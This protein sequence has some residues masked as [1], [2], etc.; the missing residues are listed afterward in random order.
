MSNALSNYTPCSSN[1]QWPRITRIRKDTTY[2]FC[3]HTAILRSVRNGI[4][5][6]QTTDLRSDR[7]VDTRQADGGI[8]KYLVERIQAL[9]IDFCPDVEG[10]GTTW[11]FKSARH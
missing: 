8:A 4:Q 11:S 5:G 10:N 6:S 9:A 7:E 2:L 1:D 3:D